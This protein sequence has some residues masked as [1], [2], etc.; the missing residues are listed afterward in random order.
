MRD[1]DPATGRYLQSDPLGLQVD[2]AL[3]TVE[4]NTYAY[5]LN[6]PIINTDPMGLSVGGAARVGGAA[7]LICMRIKACKKA[8]NKIVD[9]CKEV[10][11]RFER[12]N[13][14][15]YFPG[16]GWCEHYSLRCYI[17]GKRNSTFFEGQWPFPG[18]CVSKKPSGPLPMTK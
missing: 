3:N 17:K 6:N 5:V 12:H 16:K 9:T 13:A 8:L 15:H 4:I 10:E 2:T 11:C 7:I 18:R 14:H 1:Y